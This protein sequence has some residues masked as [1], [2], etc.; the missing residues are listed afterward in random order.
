MRRACD[1]RLGPEA[2]EGAQE[3]DRGDGCGAGE[4]PCD[5]AD[6]CCGEVVAP[7]LLHDRDGSAQRAGCLRGLTE[8]QVGDAP[9]EVAL[10]EVPGVRADVGAILQ[11]LEGG[12]GFA[13]DAGDPGAEE[14]RADLGG[15]PQSSGPG[16]RLVGNGAAALLV[17]AEA[18]RKRQ[19]PEHE[20]LP[21]RVR[22][23]AHRVE[24]FL[25]ACDRHFRVVR[26]ECGD[27]QARQR[28]RRR[29]ETGVA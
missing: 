5:G 28:E 22:G 23:C 17:A 26:F 27:P 13:G 18:A 4:E 6:H 12:L 9:E 24:R 29:G 19:V 16:Q 25:A 7:G 14:R 20:D 8:P 11:Q 1:A 21:E 3:L 15:V 2:V 10:A